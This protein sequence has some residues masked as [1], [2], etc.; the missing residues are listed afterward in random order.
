[1]RNEVEQPPLD[2]GGTGTSAA[3]CGDGVLLFAPNLPR[4]GPTPERS[5]RPA[6]GLGNIVL[7][8]RLTTG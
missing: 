8:H 4:V 6:G 2:T 3:R 5:F 1:M 7:S